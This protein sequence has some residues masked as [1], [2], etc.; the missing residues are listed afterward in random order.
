MALAEC[1]LVDNVSGPRAQYGLENN[2]W[3]E[4]T[5]FGVIRNQL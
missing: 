2:Y 4:Y 5:R 3:K 1:D